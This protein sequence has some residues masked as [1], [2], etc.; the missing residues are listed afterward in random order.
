MGVKPAAA[1]STKTA[2][3][4]MSSTIV[5]T[6]KPTTSTPTAAI[7]RQFPSAQCV[8]RAV[9]ARSAKSA[10]S[11]PEIP[12]QVDRCGS[13]TRTETPIASAEAEIQAT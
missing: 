10:E 5:L 11:T 3:P 7:H 9:T 2:R 13:K 8:R 4:V 12:R 1:V 6:A